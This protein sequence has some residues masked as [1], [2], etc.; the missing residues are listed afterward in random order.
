MPVEKPSTTATPSAVPK[1]PVAA[2]VA[3]LPVAAA[4]AV[5]AD[6]TAQPEKVPEEQKVFPDMQ[7]LVGSLVRSSQVHFIEFNS[8][9]R[10]KIVQS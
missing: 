5:A 6:T 10:T 1:P 4:T 7:N 9:Y 3:A 8:W 2:A